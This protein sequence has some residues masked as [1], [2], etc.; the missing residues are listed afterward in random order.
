MSDLSKFRGC[1]LAGAAGDALG[2]PVEFMSASDIRASY[3][4]VRDYHPAYGR[5]GAIT[6]DT[7]MTLFTAEAV[8]RHLRDGAGPLERCLREAYLGWFAT[9]TA[10]YEPGLGGML[11]HEG[12]WSRRAPGNTCLGSLA[13]ISAGREV[14][15]ESK[16]CG[17]VM[18]AAPLGLAFGGWEAYELGKMS[19]RLTHRHEDGYAPA[20]ALAMLVGLLLEGEGFRDALVRCMGRLA[21]DGIGKGTLLCLQRALAAA[22][23]GRTRHDQVIP[24]IGAGWTGDEA[25]AIA[26]YAALVARDLEEGVVIAANHGGDTDSTASI[27]G[28]ILGVIHG[29]EAIPGRW[30][31]GLELSDLIGDT[32]EQLH[33]AVA[34]GV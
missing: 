28:N 15:S 7:Q 27:A 24:G 8:L 26:A 12:L 1:L 4:T 9:Q 20:G 23:T 17:G 33:E 3:G 21:M 32:A 18:R 29:E 19:A 30:L 2:A 25:L 5:T 6:D 13:D 34:V 10:E 11:A 22:E 16:G 31:D 14:R